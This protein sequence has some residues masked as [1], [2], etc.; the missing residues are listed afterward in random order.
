VIM[1]VVFEPLS[2]GKLSHGLWLCL[3]WPSLLRECCTSST[4]RQLNV[5]GG[6]E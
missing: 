3:C 2:D 6:P 1:M 4:H 5:L